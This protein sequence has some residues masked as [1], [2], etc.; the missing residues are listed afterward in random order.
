MDKINLQDT[1]IHKFMGK[2]KLFRIQVIEEEFT[3]NWIYVDAE[4]SL[5]ISFI[6]VNITIKTKESVVENSESVVENFGRYVFDQF[7]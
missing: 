6:A 2:D 4:M 3:D 1:L 5:R 7:F